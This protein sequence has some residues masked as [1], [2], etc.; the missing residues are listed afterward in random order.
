[1]LKVVD[2][3]CA[4]PK[5]VR[6]LCI[7]E[8]SQIQALERLVPDKAMTFGRIQLREF[9]YHRHGVLNLMAAFDVKTGTVFGR[10]FPRNRHEEFLE[11]CD[12]LFDFYP[13]EPLICIL[14]NLKTHKHEKV[15][16]RI[17]Q[18]QGRV[19]FQFLPTHASWLNQVGDLVFSFT[20]GGFVA[21]FFFGFA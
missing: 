17:R 7:D 9:Y 21:W 2:L 20:A 13:D 3:Y 16:E 5:G 18:E 15:M 10:C 12:E 4:P 11:F 8:K 14:D 19:R 1:M 6:L